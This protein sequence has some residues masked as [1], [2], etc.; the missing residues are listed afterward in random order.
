LE[1]TKRWGS[2]LQFRQLAGVEQCS[3]CR[4]AAVDGI[5]RGGDGSVTCLGC[6]I[7]QSVGLSEWRPVSRVVNDLTSVPA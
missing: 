1:I 5:V 3:V 6:A 2:S 4:A 7:L